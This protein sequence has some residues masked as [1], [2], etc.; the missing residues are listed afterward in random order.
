MSFK[1]RTS[2]MLGVL[3]TTALITGVLAGC[4]SG[5]ASQPIGSKATGT[6]QF[7]TRS[8]IAPWTKQVVANFN[9]SHKDVQVKLTSIE[10]A[11][12]VTKLSTVLRTST[13]PDLVATDDVDAIPFI[14][15]H[16]F[17]DLTS[18][19]KKAGLD[20]S[21]NAAQLDLATIDGKIYGTPAV[22]DLS[23]LLY[24]KDLFAKAGITAPPTTLTEVVADA[25]KIRALGGNTYGFTQ[26]LN[27]SGCLTFTVLP[28]V[29]AAKSDVFSGGLDDQKATVSGNAALQQTLEAYR[30]LWS[31][32][33]MPPSDRAADGSTWGSVMAKGNIGMAPG[34][35]F[36]R[37]SLPAAKQANIGV[38]PLPGPMGGASTY[39]GGASF[40]I[41]AK[42]KNAAGAWEF[43]KFAL[44]QEQQELAPATGYSPVLTSLADDSAFLAKYPYLKAGL[45][46]AKSGNAPKTLYHNEIF[47]QASGPWLQMFQT[48][49]IKGNVSGALTTGQTG[50]SSVLSGNN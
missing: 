14:D 40:A 43:V 47:T 8:A 11:N 13:V 6:V 45:D 22:S 36:I 4:S 30:E 19:V 25:K 24:N 5:G 2:R 21:V 39:V 50:F 48:A 32:G 27:C 31:S 49:V 29:Y 23:V 1:S 26:Q 37:A 10:D 7:W 18:Q 33:V 20:S 38:T 34:G 12:I 15:K 9:K 17:L 42:A 46:A 16:L 28:S 41:P 35:L 44:S 3:T